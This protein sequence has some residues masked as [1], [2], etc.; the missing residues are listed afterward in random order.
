MFSFHSGLHCL[1][2]HVFIFS[3]TGRYYTPTGRLVK[4]HVRD[5]GFVGFL[6]THKC[7]SCKEA[8]KQVDIGGKPCLV[9]LYLLHD[10]LC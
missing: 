3:N 8:A 4:W 10:Y 5:F 9:L 2:R 6:G 1:A 7:N